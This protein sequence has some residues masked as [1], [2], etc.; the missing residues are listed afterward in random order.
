MTDL[1]DNTPWEM[2]A[3]IAGGVLCALAYRLVAGL[4]DKWRIRNYVT[5]A[6]GTV[7]SCRWSPF[8]PGWLGE[9][10]DRIYSVGYLDNAGSEHRAYCKTS[11]FTGVYFSQDRRIGDQPMLMVGD[12]SIAALQAEIERLR[13][14][15]GMLRQK[16]QGK[17]L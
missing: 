16:L 9:K 12:Q 15:N 10:H 6:G 5:T 8:G 7:L 17:P 14:E 4:L 2:I 1:I 3:V 13:A 11:M